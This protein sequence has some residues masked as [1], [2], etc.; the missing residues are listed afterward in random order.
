VEKMQMYSVYDKGLER[1]TPPMFCS[2]EVEAKRSFQ[3]FAKPLDRSIFEGTFSL[4]LIGLFDITT[5]EIES[6]GP[7]LIE[8]NDSDFYR[9]FCNGKIEEN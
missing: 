7:D 8:S 3:Q 4:Q 1:F 5:G 9:R 6:V 2:S